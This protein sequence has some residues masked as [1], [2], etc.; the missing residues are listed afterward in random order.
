MTFSANDPSEQGMKDKF[1]SSSGT[2]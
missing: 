1:K 2:F